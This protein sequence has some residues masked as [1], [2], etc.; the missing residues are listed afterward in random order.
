MAVYRPSDGTWYILQVEH[1]LHD[2]VSTSGGWPATCRCRATTTATGK[3]DVAVYRPSRRHLV[4]PAVEHELHDVRRPTSGGWPAT[5]RCRATTTATGRPISRCIGRRPACGTSCSRARTT[6]ATSSTVGA[7]RRHSGARRLRRR[8]QDRHRGVSAVE[9]H[10][11]HP[12]VEHELHGVVVQQLGPGGDI[13]VPGDFD[14]DGKTDVA[15]YRPSNGSVV[16]PAI[17][18]ELHGV[19][20]LAVGAGRGHSGAQTAIVELQ[21]SP[22]S[23]VLR[24]PTR[25][26]TGVY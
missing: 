9:R 13:P 21:T 2:G 26:K 16:H 10:V 18:H 6:R 17:E 23:S 22:F 8:R 20:R 4:H 19:R 15:V 1:E 25:V 24:S 5:S 14:G 11:V 3:T 7:G 12:A